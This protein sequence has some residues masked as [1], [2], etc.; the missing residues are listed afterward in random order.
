MI[1]CL[2][3]KSTFEESVPGTSIWKIWR[4]K[5]LLY[6]T[7]HC[8]A[9]FLG[10]LLNIWFHYISYLLQIEDDLMSNSEDTSVSGKHVDGQDDNQPM[11]R[12]FPK[13]TNYL[14]GTIQLDVSVSI[15]VVAL[16]SFLNNLLCTFF[17]L[18]C[19]ATFTFQF[20]PSISAS[21]FPGWA[22]WYPEFREFSSWISCKTSSG[23][24]V[25]FIL[26]LTCLFSV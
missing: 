2:Y 15:I 26:Y 23:S 10:I 6:A 3:S 9:E 11:E 5:L 18:C 21:L 24:Q 12:E 19:A 25:C 4:I 7:P 16:V 13:S 8:I 1:C 20:S 14:K 22:Q 17:S